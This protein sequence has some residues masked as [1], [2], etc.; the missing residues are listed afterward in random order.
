MRI[1]VDG[2]KMMGRG[3]ACAWISIGVLMGRMV[4]F[5]GCRKN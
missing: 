4:R 1:G 2:R 3:R 5:D